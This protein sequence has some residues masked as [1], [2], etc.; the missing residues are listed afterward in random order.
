[1]IYLDEEGMLI[2]YD[3]V[4]GRKKAISTLLASTEK[5]LGDGT[6]KDIIV[7]HS[8]DPEEGEKWRQMVE[9]KYPNASSITMMELGPTIACHVG[10][11][12][13]SIV[14]LCDHRNG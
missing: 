12:F 4:R 5:D 13:L 6:G 3:K 14:Y 9:E 1:L 7:G 8:D 2:A 10:P 11:G